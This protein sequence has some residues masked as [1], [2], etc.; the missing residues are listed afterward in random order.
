VVQVPYGYEFTNA[1][2]VCDFLL[3]YGELLKQQG[4]IFDNID[5]GYVLNWQQMAAEF[6]YWSQQGWGINSL[7]NLNPLAGALTITKPGAVVDSVVAQTS[8]NVLL[9]QNKKELSVVKCLQD[10]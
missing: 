9:D 2:V 3:S 6:L 8:E 1:S 10:V 5:N 7:I 4:V